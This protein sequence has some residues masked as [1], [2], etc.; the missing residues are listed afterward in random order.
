[1]KFIAHRGLYNDE[2]GEN[3]ISAFDN[4]FN[5]AFEG[6]ELDVRKTKDNKV[7]VIHDSFISRVSDGFGLVNNMTYNELLKYNFGKNKIERIPLLKDVIKRYKDKIIFIELKEK[8]PIEELKL[9]K[10]NKYYITSFNFDYI[11]DIPISDNYKKGLIS[12]V[13]NSKINLAKI[14][15]ILILDSLINEKTYNYYNDKMIEVII[16][17][18]GKKINVKLNNVIANNLKYI[19]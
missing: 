18:V 14:D 7:V 3:T 1:M 19:I 4:A 9:D 5:N 16:Y 2:I 13:L 8:I 17:G 11:K 6:I 15:F 10:R 12:Y